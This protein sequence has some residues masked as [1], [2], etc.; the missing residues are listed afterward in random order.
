MFMDRQ[1]AGRA[2]AKK[3]A[4][5]RGT[6]AI[7]LALPR[8]GVVTGEGIAKA[9]ALPLDIVAV[10]KIGHPVSAEYAIGAVDENGTTI[11]NEAE[12][13]SIDQS[14]LKSEI[15]LEKKE[16]ERRSITYRDGRQPLP[17]MGKTAIIVDDGIATGLT[18][19]LAVRSAKKQDA[20][21]V[22]VAVPV[23]PAESLRA[24]QM[25]GADEIIVIEPPEEFAG[26][27]GAHYVR[28]DQVEDAEVVKLLRTAYEARRTS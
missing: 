22:I 6:D 2:L 5:Y 18:M 13:K 12:T 28:F 3:L 4:P 20:A 27:V 17:L 7:V 19:R 21:K 10:R 23:A 24:L 11:L 15:E 1:E 25:E 14:W 26:A 8:G 9:L 16:A